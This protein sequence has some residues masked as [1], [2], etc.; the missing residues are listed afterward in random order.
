MNTEKI[1]LR[2]KENGTFRILMVSDIQET[3]NYDPRAVEGLRAMIQAKKPDLV[4]WGGDNCD[5]RKV[6]TREELQS[7]LEIFTL[8]MEETRTPWMHVYGNHDYDVAVPVREQSEL[9]ESYPHCISGHTPEDIPGVCN[10]M[11]PIRVHDSERTAFCIFAF[12]THHKEPELR[13]GVTVD[14]LMLPH[15]PPYYRKW[16]IIRFEQ[17]MWYWN[18]SKTLEARE[19]R[20]VPALAVMHVAP[21]EINLVAENPKES[22]LTGEIEELMQCGVLNSGI[23]A[24][25]LERGD[26]KIIAAGHSHDD[27]T[28]GVYGG[29]R[30]CLDGCAGF[31]P[32]SQDKSRGGRIF[33]L[34]EDGSYETYMVLVKD[35]IN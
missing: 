8:P 19:G 34:N 27:T 35:L 29:I 20:T 18:T 30:F 33:D 7:Y 17:Q 26:V 6:K 4:I 1:T 23:F 11:I 25:M 32:Y 2:F 28:D 31:T 21:H 3:V 5:G 12:D 9:Y 16:D 14:Q 24:T 22:G 15:R 13:P 10:Y